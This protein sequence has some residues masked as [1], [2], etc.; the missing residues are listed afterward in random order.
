MT[1]QRLIVACLSLFWLSPLVNCNNV[2]VIFIE[3]L[4]LMYS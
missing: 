4:D 3:K 2:Y 1:V